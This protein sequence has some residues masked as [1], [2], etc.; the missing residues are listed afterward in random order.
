[1]DELETVD[2]NGNLDSRNS[3]SWGDFEGPAGCSFPPS[4]CADNFHEPDCLN[5]P[6]GEWSTFGESDQLNNS[7]FPPFTGEQLKWKTSPVNMDAS[8]LDTVQ[9][10][11]DFEMV[12]KNSFPLVEVE[13]RTEDVRSLLELLEDSPQE[14]ASF[15]Q[16][17]PSR[18]SSPVSLWRSLQDENDAVGLEQQWKESHSQKRLFT[19]IGIDTTLQTLE[20]VKEDFW[21]NDEEMSDTATLPSPGTK[22]LIQTKLFVPLCS[23]NARSFIYHIS[24]QW[25]QINSQLRI[26]SKKK[27]FLF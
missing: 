25:L 20:T 12:F 14:E 4:N 21:E 5:N 18:C 2:C 15:Y 9:D 10:V 16:H 6:F 8:S 1:M 19:T 23:R 22:D 27:G 24:H 26:Q 17:L 7:A 11:T 13:E 3:Q